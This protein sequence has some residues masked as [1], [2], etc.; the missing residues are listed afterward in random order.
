MYIE[1]TDVAN[2]IQRNVHKIGGTMWQ[3]STG[4]LYLTKPTWDLTDYTI[5][6]MWEHS[7]PSLELTKP[8]K[9]IDVVMYDIF[10]NEGSSDAAVDSTIKTTEIGSNGETLVVDNPYV[11]P[12]Y[13]DPGE[14]YIVEAYRDWYKHRGMLKGEF[15]ADPRL[16]LFDVISVQSKYG[17][18]SPVM[19]TYIKYTY[20]G[21]FHGTFEGKILDPTVVATE[22]EVT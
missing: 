21:S 13:E 8:L 12:Y 3:G 20:N 7:H 19:V 10:R 6:G 14:Q 1:T 16:E 4:V 22:T 9:Q 18:I 11:L 5:S 17:M 2:F 15:R